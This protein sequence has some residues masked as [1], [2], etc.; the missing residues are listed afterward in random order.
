MANA[1]LGLELGMVGHLCLLE[2]AYNNPKPRHSAKEPV[3]ASDVSH[4]DNL[5]HHHM[6]AHIIPLRRHI[7]PLRRHNYIH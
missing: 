6:Y 5:V 7:I 2:G 4:G 3:M 1:H